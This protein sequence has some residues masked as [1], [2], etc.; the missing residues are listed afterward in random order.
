MRTRQVGEAVDTALKNGVQN[1][2]SDKD[3]GE[4]ESVDPGA[5]GAGVP[6]GHEP[7][8]DQVTAGEARRCRTSQGLRVGGA[9]V[10]PGRAR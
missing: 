10:P 6:W 1:V 8:I 4:R 9:R 7:S 5:R 3:A 2:N